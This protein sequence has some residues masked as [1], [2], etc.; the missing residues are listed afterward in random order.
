MRP[1]TSARL[2]AGLIGVLALLGMPACNSGPYLTVHSYQPARNA[3]GTVTIQILAE[4]NPLGVDR[5]ETTFCLE[6]RWW[7]PATDGGV[8][9]SGAAAT[10]DDATDCHSVSLDKGG[11]AS[12]TVT[13]TKALDP[14]LNVDIILH[15]GDAQG[16]PT[17]DVTR[18]SP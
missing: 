17:D 4:C 5:C 7:A 11:L 15:R 1:T 3:D 14:G 13:S 12:F 9:H 18:A 10:V 6:A 16:L 2:A 8:T